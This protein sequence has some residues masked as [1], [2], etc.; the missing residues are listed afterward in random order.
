MRNVC[1]FRARYVCGSP[2]VGEKQWLNKNIITSTNK[3]TETMLIWSVYKLVYLIEFS[4]NKQK[5]Q[6]IRMTSLSWMPM[7]FMDEIPVVKK[8][9]LA[10]LVPE[11][12]LYFSLTSV[13][14][15]RVK[16]SILNT[17][18][19]DRQTIS[20]LEDLTNI[21]IFAVRWY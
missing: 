11:I 18:F 8:N 10:C 12:M 20:G 16:I 9:L 1:Y 14:S 15:V 2:L 17:D 6:A 21:S 5:S 19:Q 7:Q 13:F 3:E 4:G